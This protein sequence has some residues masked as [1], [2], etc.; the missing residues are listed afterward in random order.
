VIYYIIF[1]N[2][3]ASSSVTNVNS[4]IVIRKLL[5]S[6]FY[7]LRCSYAREEL[8]HVYTG[9]FSYGWLYHVWYTLVRGVDGLNST[10]AVRLWCSQDSG[11]QSMTADTF[12]L[13]EY[14]R[15][16]KVSIIYLL[17]RQESNAPVQPWAIILFKCILFCEW[18]SVNSRRSQ[19]DIES[20]GNIRTWIKT[21]IYRHILH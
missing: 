16:L 5:Y 12:D 11:K 13:P 8:E 2:E 14:L 10:V 6:V 15:I 21:F 7:V 17:T 19:M 1:W 20:K 4:Y 18:E 9:P 3:D